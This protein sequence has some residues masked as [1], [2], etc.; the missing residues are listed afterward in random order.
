MSERTIPAVPPVGATGL[1]R[2]VLITIGAIVVLVVVAVLVAVFLPDRPTT[3]PA[4]SPEAAFQDY[5]DAWTAGDLETAYAGLS[6]TVRSDLDLETYRRIDA[7]QSWQRTM[8]RRVVLLGAD[9]TGERALLRLRIDQFTSGG[10]GGDRYS[11]ERTVR[12]VR[13]DGAWRIDEPLVGTEL[14]WYKG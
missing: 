14:G 4:G 7:E 3:Y 6:S 11:E 13:E 1:P 5:L 8:D 12:M 10:F 9:V 2:S